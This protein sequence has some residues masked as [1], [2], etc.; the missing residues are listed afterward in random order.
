GFVGEGSAARHHTDASGSVDVA[1]HDADLAL[2]GC[3]DARAVRPDQAGRLPLEPALDAH[4]VEDGHPLGDAHHERD[5]RVGR[6]EDGVGRARGRNVDDRRVGARG[7]D[8]LCHG[9]EDRDALEVGPT[10]ARRHAGDHLGTVLAAEARVELP[11]GAG[12]ALGEDTRVLRD[13]DAH[14]PLPVAATAFCAPSSMSV[15]VMMSSPD[16]ARICFPCSTFVA[17]MRTTSG[18]VSPTSFAAWT[19]PSA[20]TSQRRMPPKMLM[21]MA[22]TAASERMILKAALTFSVSAPPP[23]SRKLAGSPPAALTESIVAIA[24]PAPFTM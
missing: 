1:R 18:T 14:R 8:G 24:S 21:K 15:A 20:S 11:G 17:C 16:S 6:F 10:A 7:G 12:D 4:H 19:T 9:V 22:C 2:V 5:A 23:T 3:D 13:Q